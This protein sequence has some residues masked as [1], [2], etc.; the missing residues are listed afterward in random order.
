MT[1]QTKRQL[2]WEILHLNKEISQMQ[3][4]RTALKEAALEETRASNARTAEATRTETLK[5]VIEA[6]EL[7]QYGYVKSNS[8]YF[9]GGIEQPG[10]E[11]LWADIEAAL[12][13]RAEEKHAK[14]REAADDR[15][16]KLT[17]SVTGVASSITLSPSDVALLQKV[18]EPFSWGGYIP[19][20]SPKVGLVHSDEKIEPAP[21][22]KK[23]GKKK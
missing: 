11:R 18:S 9:G 4:S 19:N 12:E 14:T 2:R 5:K 16:R 3:S 20:P 13:L 7:T 21:S 6:L 17:H 22:A 23:D 1:F 15:V 8:Y 10:H